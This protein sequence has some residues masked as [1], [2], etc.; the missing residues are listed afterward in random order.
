MLR[1]GWREMER[2]S[3]RSLR[4]ILRNDGMALGVSRSSFKTRNR[5]CSFN[6]LT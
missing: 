4:K 5:L 3:F 6:N 2:R 1:E